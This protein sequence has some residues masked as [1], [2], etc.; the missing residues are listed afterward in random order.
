[1]VGMPRGPVEIVYPTTDIS[2]TE[3]VHT[4][5]CDI[6]GPRGEL[7]SKSRRC[8]T[9]EWVS[10]HFVIFKDIIGMRFASHSRTRKID[11]EDR[12]IP[13]AVFEWRRRWL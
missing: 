12:S 4:A 8:L 2:T 9:W 7:H 10:S 6:A 5:C 13:I 11:G 1:M 3:K